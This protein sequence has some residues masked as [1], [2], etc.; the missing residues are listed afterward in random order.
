VVFAA[1]FR[2]GLQALFESGKLKFPIGME[3]LCERP[4]FARWLRRCCRR[5]RWVVY[6]RRPFAGPKTVLAYLCRYTRRVGLTNRPPVAFDPGTHKVTL[7][8]KDYA[9]GNSRKTVTLSSN[10][11]LRRF[12][13]HILPPRFVKIRHYGLLANRDRDLRLAK[14]KDLLKSTPA[15]LEA[16]FVATETLRLLQDRPLLCPHRGKPSLILVAITHP[17]PLHG[18]PLDDTS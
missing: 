6:A 4:A 18:P 12:C 17:A 14:V 13:L 7:R 10:E 16:S 3:K 11:F 1:K 2:D 9:D 8:Y 5:Q 15:P